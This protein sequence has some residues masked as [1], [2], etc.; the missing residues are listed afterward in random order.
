MQP[1]KLDSLARL[2]DDLSRAASVEEVYTVSLD[3]LQ[4]SLGVERAS[5][6][7]FDT[8]E[9]MNFVAWRG[10]SDQYRSAVTG[11]TPWRPDSRDP[12]P[13]LVPDAEADPSLASYREVFRAEGIRALGF[14]AL[15]H[16]DRVIGKFMLYYA[17]PHDFS[18]EEVALAKTIA[19]QIAFG[20]TRVLAEQALEA[21]RERLAATVSSVPGMVWETVG[22]FPGEQKVTFVSDGIRQLIGYEPEDW[23]RN[24]GFWNSIIVERLGGDMETIAASSMRDSVPALHFY[25]LRTRDGRTIWAEVRSAH[26]VVNGMLAS[27]GVTM[28][29]T[30]RMRAEQRSAFLAEA[31]GVLSA[32]L[33]YESSLSHVADLIVGTL[34][35]WCVIDIIEEDHVARVAVRHRDPAKA[36][37]IQ[38]LRDQFPPSKHEL[39]LGRR[40]IETNAPIL[41]KQLDANATA[42]LKASPAAA[43]FDELGYESAVVVPITAAGHSFGAISIVSSDSARR[44]DENDLAVAVELGRRAGYAVDHARLYRQAQAANRAKDEFLATL[45]HEL[46]TPMTAT[47]G[48]ASMLRM[49]DT[50]P[51]TFRLA[52]DTIERSIRAQAKLIDDIFDVSRIVTG[53]LQLQ[54][55]PVDLPRVIQAAVE[56]LQPSISAKS[57]RL[58]V[59]Y[60]NVTE[61]LLGDAA[62]LQQVIWNLLSNA[63]KFTPPLGTIRIDVRRSSNHEVQVSVRDSGQGISP[64]MLPFVFER[65][66][67]GD[68]SATR[69]HGGLG[70]GLAIVKNLV[71]LHGGAVVAESEGEGRGAMFTVTLPLTRARAQDGSPASQAD[72][73]AV[74]LAGIVVL[75]VE[76]DDDTRIMLTKTLEYC[77]ATVVAAASAAAALDELRRRPPHIVV[78]D[79]AMPG[80]DGYSL[81]TKIRAGA[82]ES[83]RDVP[84]I[85][86]TA[87]ARP[88]D[89]QRILAAGFREQLSKPVDT[90]VM[91]RAVRS[92]VAP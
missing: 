27:R 69:A 75:V 5:I 10:L 31:G 67:Q 70:L 57:L 92:L 89:R 14:F 63:V 83:C 71:E 15:T 87:F 33:D 79:I 26:K 78:S 8:N 12:E 82:V 11:H 90:M 88:E 23:Y 68:S 84:A 80:E 65:F 18:S 6:L 1:A 40:V 25:K 2:T 22:S 9:V 76:D 44:Y 17:A 52:I 59:A 13:V 72:A 91:L 85:A 50:T 45:S 21:E 46:R 43:I 54:V 51:E 64:R 61:P 41:L 39:G 16:R 20:V 53:K 19:G 73:N 55:A 35:D 38:K 86:V 7:L 4:Q 47:L 29:I 81:I 77:G 66:R 30:E 74:S 28:D 24:P 58:E 37:L 48:W 34:G 36:P 56:T 62:R 49:G 3:C 60:D 42:L 32:T